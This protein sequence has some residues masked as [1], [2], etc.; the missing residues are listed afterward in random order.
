MKWDS[1]EIAKMLATEPGL[2][3]LA[4]HYSTRLD[5]IHVL[6]CAMATGTNMPEADQRNFLKVA[7]GHERDRTTRAVLRFAAC[8]AIL[9]EMLARAKAEQPKPQPQGAGRLD[10]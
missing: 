3:K 5:D 7:A 4:E 10:N 8:G 1:Q 2:N 6:A 9:V